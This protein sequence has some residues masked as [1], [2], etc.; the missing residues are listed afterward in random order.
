[1]PLCTLYH[2]RYVN[3]RL[4]LHRLAPSYSMLYNVVAFTEDW[5]KSHFTGSQGTP[6]FC[7]ADMLYFLMQW[8]SRRAATSRLTK[9]QRPHVDGFKWASLRGIVTFVNIFIFD[10]ASLWRAATK[11][12]DKTYD[13]SF[14]LLTWW[15]VSYTPAKNMS[16][17]YDVLM[18]TH[19]FVNLD[20]SIEICQK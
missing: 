11:E 10:L 8:P 2:L 7:N 14:V 17:C 12:L 16:P 18:A 15:V 13:S 6:W 4:T 5:N 3:L 1:M 19:Y 20:V 9:Q